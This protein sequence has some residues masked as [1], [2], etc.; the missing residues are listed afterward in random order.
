VTTT[1]TLGGNASGQLVIK[2]HGLNHGQI[3][4]DGNW[5][6]A[7][8]P[9]FEEYLTNLGTALDN[10][11]VHLASAAAAPGSSSGLYAE[12]KKLDELRRDRLLSQEEF[13]IQKKKLL[14]KN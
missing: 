10:A 2:G 14:E 7:F 13:E 11:R 4:K 1:L 3:V 12:L 8:E 6:E 9:A 5:Q